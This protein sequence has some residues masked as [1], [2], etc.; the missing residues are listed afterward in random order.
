MSYILYL[1]QKNP[2]TQLTLKQHVDWG[3]R[4]S[5][6]SK[7]HIQLIVSHLRRP[8]V[9]VDSTNQG[10]W[11]TVVITTEKKLSI[12][13]TTPF[14]YAFFKSQLYMLTCL[15]TRAIPWDLE[16]KLPC[17]FYSRHQEANCSKDNTNIPLTSA[18]SKPLYCLLCIGCK[19]YYNQ[20]PEPS[21][22][23]SYATEHFRRM[24]FLHVKLVVTT[25]GDDTWGIIWQCLKDIFSCCKLGGGTA[26]GI[27]W[28]G[29]LVRQ[30][31]HWMQSTGQSNT[32]PSYSK[33]PQWN[34]FNKIRVLHQWARS[35]FWHVSVSEGTNVL[36]KQ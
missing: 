32:Q 20:N 4:P 24:Y 30:P 13:G 2:H 29:M 36:L 22:I 16:Q 17:A 31:N 35:H 6:C 15:E 11:S 27:Q 9:S 1:F 26:T 7:I 25:S 8:L 28:L 19:K 18:T 21:S 3:W 12:R 5:I 33:G 34:I 14:K 23:F 10:S